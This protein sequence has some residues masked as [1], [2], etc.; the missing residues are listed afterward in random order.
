MYAAHTQN[1]FR[2]PHLGHSES[3]NA[4]EI[5]INCMKHWAIYQSQ[6]TYAIMH[7]NWNKI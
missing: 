1:T 2:S 4:R 7:F 6:S 3:E 5:S